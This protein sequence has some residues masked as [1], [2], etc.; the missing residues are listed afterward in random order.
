M[1][2]VSAASHT[3]ALPAHL[4]QEVLTVPLSQIIN[5]IDKRAV[6]LREQII[7]VEDLQTMLKCP[8][9][10]AREHGDML[11]VIVSSGAEELGLIVDSLVDE[12]DMVIKPLPASLKNLQMVSGAT[13]GGNNEVFSVLNVTA[14]IRAAREIRTESAPVMESIQDKSRKSV[15]VVDD[16]VNTRELEKNI[17]EAYGYNVDL[18]DDGMMALEKVNQ[19]MYDAIVTD[20]EM[21]QLDGFSLTMRLRRDERYRDVP[22]IIVTSRARDEDRKRGIQLGANAYIVKGSFDQNNLIDTVRNLIG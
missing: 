21:P 12:A 3:F 22:I 6:R 15:L 1:L 19:R 9:T 13:I 18:A 16:S 2:L 11:V 8:G 20:V 4:I 10:A 17:L 7:P 14:L 5:V